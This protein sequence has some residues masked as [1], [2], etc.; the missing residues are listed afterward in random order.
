VDSLEDISIF[1][2]VLVKI[3]IVLWLLLLIVYIIIVKINRNR[4][5]ADRMKLK[6]Y[7][8]KVCIL[9]VDVMKNGDRIV[10]NE[11]DVTDQWRIEKDVFEDT[12][13]EVI[14]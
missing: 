8:K 13:E 14:E 12:Y 9:V 6:K 3:L 1:L 2:K 4:R 11:E 5:G 10:C 7:K